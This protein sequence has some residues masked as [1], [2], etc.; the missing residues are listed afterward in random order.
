M[1]SVL[2]TISLHLTIFAGSFAVYLVI[3]AI[4]VRI[5]RPRPELGAGRGFEPSAFASTP[6]LFADELLRR[7]VHPHEQDVATIQRNCMQGRTEMPA[8]SWKIA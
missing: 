5:A 4:R 8:A 1:I 6:S 3:M 7:V 2:W